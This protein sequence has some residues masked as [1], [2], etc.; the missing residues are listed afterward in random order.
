[1]DQKVEMLAGVP[2]L[3]G[4][5]RKDLE[6]IAQLC[7]EVDVPAGRTVARQGAVGNEF[8]VI[9]DG[10]V[11]IEQEGRHLTDLGPGQ[12]FGELA[13]LANISR[14]ASATCTTDSRLLVLGHR[15]F[16]SLVSQ[17]PSV[18]GALLTAVAQRI[19]RIEPKPTN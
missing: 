3:A 14:T 12:F 17:F 13:L 19:A 5:G 16:N 8:F 15:E 1:M 18:Q 11:A 9:L 7:D 2:L 6:A 4:L 10:S